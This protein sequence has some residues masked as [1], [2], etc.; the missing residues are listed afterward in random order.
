ME[1]P[2]ARRHPRGGDDDARPPDVV[3]GLR[4]LRAPRERELRRPER[5]HAGGEETGHLVVLVLA[6]R[7][8]DRRRVHRHGRVH[9]D[10]YGRDLAL[11]LELPDGEQ[12]LLG[13]ADGEGGDEERA[14]RPDHRPDLVPERLRG[15]AR[16]VVLAPV[17][18]LHE[19]EVVPGGRGGGGVGE[20]GR[21]VAAEVAAEED[22][23]RRR[24]RDLHLDRGA[25]EDV[26]GAP[27]GDRDPLRDLDAPRVG[28]GREPGQDAERVLL[29]VERLGVRGVLRVA[30]LVR[31]AGLLLLEPPRVGQEQPRQVPGGRGA[32]HRP[33]V[34][35]PVQERERARVIHVGVRDH[36]RV[37]GPRV[38]R[39][40]GAV[41]EAELLRALEEAR[42]HEHARPARL[43]EVP[44]AGHRPGRTEEPDGRHLPAI[45]QSSAACAGRSGW[46][47]R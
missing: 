43:D 18:A 27:E 15:P 2:A 37:E 28:G 8:V 21:A 29:G 30:L 44:G 42:V 24:A 25:P 5:L 23:Q 4:L 14:L 26:A 46:S 6:V 33:R 22:A 35:G 16:R 12:E 1:H 40:G 34:A 3:Q 36:D 32:M 13:S 11:P 39:P 45:L 47:G 41:P 20:D 7:E 17:G 31:E 9:E 10:R 19:E 38:Q